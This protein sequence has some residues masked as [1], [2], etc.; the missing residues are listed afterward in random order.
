[1][2]GKAKT[3]CQRKL[4]V[5]V[6]YKGSCL[7]EDNGLHDDWLALNLKEDAAVENLATAIL[8]FP[9]ID[10]EKVLFIHDLISNEGE[11]EK[12]LLM[13]VVIRFAV[14]RGYRYIYI[15]SVRHSR[16]YLV[17]REF[18]LLSQGGLAVRKLNL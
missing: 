7:I 5:L 18:T 6:D 12:D 3:G 10:G 8:N 4:R 9:V 17:S 14:K 13:D 1:M 11:E 16:E 15:Y 2:E